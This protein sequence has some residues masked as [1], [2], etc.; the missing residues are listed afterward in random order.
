MYLILET[1]ENFLSD[2]FSFKTI[3][4][5][6]DKRRKHKNCYGKHPA[7]VSWNTFRSMCNKG[8]K[9]VELQE[10]EDH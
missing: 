9:S 7:Y 3:H 1:V 8:K 10:Q 6:I 4:K 5:W 2:L